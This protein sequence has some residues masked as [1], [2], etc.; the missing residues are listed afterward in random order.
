MNP[1]VA[2]ALKKQ[3]LQLRSAAL[4]I[5]LAG[6]AAAF[7]PVFAT[8]D[9]VC[10]GAHWLRRHPEVG[11][12]VGVALVVARPRAVWRWSRRGFVVW[13]AWN[14]ARAWLDDKRRA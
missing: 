7:A 12:A 14:R 4:R 8:G 11:V 9:K 5:E 13:Q 1:E 10:A 6:H 3:R 2:L